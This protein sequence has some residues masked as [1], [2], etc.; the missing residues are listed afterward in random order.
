M[1]RLENFISFHSTFLHALNPRMEIE[2]ND[3]P[4][5]TIKLANH[6]LFCHINCSH[7]IVNEPQTNRIHRISVIFNVEAI[8]QKAMNSN[9]QCEMKMFFSLKF[10][11]D[12]SFTLMIIM[13]EHI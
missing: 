11:D 9:Y 3:I 12:F 4:T 5:Q 1:E 6:F 7:R 10:F 8:T 2:W 13:N